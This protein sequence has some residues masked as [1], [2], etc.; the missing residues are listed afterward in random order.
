MLV[1]SMTI[2]NFASGWSRAIARE[3]SSR[4]FV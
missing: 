2:F 3:Q 4:S 1:L